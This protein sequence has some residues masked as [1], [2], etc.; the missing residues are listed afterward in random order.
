M[1]ATDDAADR[2][3][4]TR[5]R[6]STSG[7]RCSPTR[8][9]TRAGPVGARRLA[10]RRPAAT[11]TLVA[12]LTRLYGRRARPGSTRPTPRSLRRLDT[13]RAAAGRRSRRRGDARA[14]A[15]ADRT[16]LHCGPADRPGTDVCDPLRR[17]MRAAVVA[18]GWAAD[19]AEADALLAAGEVRAASRPTATTPSCRWPARS[20]RRA[21]VFVVDD[22]RRA[23]PARSRRS[24]R[25][26][27]RSP[28]SAGRRR[29]RSTG[30]C[31]C[32]TS[33]GRCC[34]DVVGRAGP[35]RRAS[36]WPPRASQ[37]GDDVHMRTQATTNLL[38]RNLLPAADRGAAG[39]R[40]GSSWRASSPA[41]TCSS[42]TWRWRGA[43]R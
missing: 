11:R 6:S 26:R 12:A 24:T 4:A 21:P 33:P 1:S 2:A 36:P 42:S 31:S 10:H 22:R 3:A 28:G 41:T 7:C 40:G 39:R 25:A 37:M 5:S 15:S 32:A 18:E 20:G 29:P 43:S 38:L 34:A 30:W 8:S 27:A 13:G 14:R 35:A 9:A 19:V 23:A 16:L 17:S